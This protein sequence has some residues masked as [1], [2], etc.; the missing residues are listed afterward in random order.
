M[1]GVWFRVPA[2]SSSPHLPQFF[3]RAAAASS[4]VRVTWVGRPACGAMP[5]FM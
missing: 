3:S 5:M 4:S 2:W 1:A